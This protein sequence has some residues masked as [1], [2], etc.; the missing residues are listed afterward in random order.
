[1]AEKKST[2]IR[3]EEIV[4]AA[5]QVI[6]SRGVGALTISAI[7]ESAGMSE[8]NIYRH[9]P[10]K[11]EIYL[12]VAEFIGANLMGKAATMAA[13][14]GSP[15]AKLRNIYQFHIA[16]VAE[17]PGIPRFIFSEQVHLGDSNVSQLVATRVGGYVETLTGLFAAGINEGEFNAGLAPRETALTLLGMIQ[18]MALRWSVCGASFDIKAE[19]DR[20]WDNFQL[21]VK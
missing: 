15:M 1:M 18:F 21:M 14:S 20:M 8:A 19:A 3:K 17:L 7:A 5:L 6:G 10:G 11:R 12:A 16:T 4:H 2:R 13:G 9:F